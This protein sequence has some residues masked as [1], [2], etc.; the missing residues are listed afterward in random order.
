MADKY[1]QTSGNW[2]NDDPSTG[3]W[4]D[5]PS[6][7]TRVG[8]PEPGDTAY[9]NAT[10]TVTLDVDPACDLIEGAGLLVASVNRLITADMRSNSGNLLHVST[11][12]TL[13]VAGDIYGGT[14]TGAHTLRM[15]HASAKLLHIG[16]IIGASNGGFRYAVQLSAGAGHELDE[17][18]GGSASSAIAVDVGAA[19]VKIAR[20]EGGS[21][22][23][24]AAVFAS[25]SFGTTE[26]ALAKGG[27]HAEAP[28]VNHGSGTLAIEAVDPTGQGPIIGGGMLKLGDGVVLP[29]RDLAGNPRLYHG[30]T[31]AEIAAAMWHDDTSP[32]RTTTE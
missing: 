20:A 23:A 4:F 22:A 29:L 1:A 3:I 10:A 18:I 17:V 31:P 15:N 21:A 28:A 7:G 30:T 14:A 2:S 16:R 27:S 26:I 32:E 12:L 8:V 19:S 25:S 11:A 5:A 24:A 6:G 9:I 13:S